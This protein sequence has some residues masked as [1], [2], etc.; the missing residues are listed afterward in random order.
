VTQA[1]ADFKEHRTA[2]EQAKG[3]SIYVYQITADA[4]FELLIWRSQ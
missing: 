4:A 2:I 1:V 3:V